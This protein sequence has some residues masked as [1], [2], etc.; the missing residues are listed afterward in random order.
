MNK[1]A[2]FTLLEVLLALFILVTALYVLSQAQIKSVQRVLRNR[3]EV[4]RIFLVKKAWLEA[5]IKPSKDNK[6]S[7]T[8]KFKDP[9]V[10]IITA[11]QKLMRSLLNRAQKDIKKSR[12]LLRAIMAQGEWTSGLF[13]EKIVVGG[14]VYKAEEKEEKK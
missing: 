1:P 12:D 10:K 13:N 9:E 11:Q 7:V 14:F 8:Q 2:G 6:K 5:F 4:N 3:E